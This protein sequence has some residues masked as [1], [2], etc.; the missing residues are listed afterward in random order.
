MNGILTSHITVED[1][2]ETLPIYRLS[3]IATDYKL[4]KEG[5][6]KYLRSALNERYI[7]LELDTIEEVLGKPTFD[8]GTKYLYFPNQLPDGYYVSFKT[9]YNF[10]YFGDLEYKTT[11][12]GED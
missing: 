8:V 9:T 7:E 10:E 11:K 3:V 4:C 6:H 5:I 1:K 2:N 12:Y